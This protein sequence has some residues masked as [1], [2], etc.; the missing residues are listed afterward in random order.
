VNA[1][2]IIAE[3]AICVMA[4]EP[5][6]KAYL[7]VSRDRAARANARRDASPANFTTLGGL[8]P[9]SHASGPAADT[10]PAGP[11]LNGTAEVVS[12]VDPVTRQFVRADGSNKA[13]DK[14]RSGVS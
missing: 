13:L 12:R 10:T 8:F 2:L 4:I 7:A 9:H 3:T 11:V 14:L 1:A 5:A 6:T